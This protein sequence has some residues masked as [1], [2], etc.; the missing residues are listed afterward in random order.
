MTFVSSPHPATILDEKLLK[1]CVI[2]VGR[3]NSGPGGQHRNK[4]ETSVRI[5]HTPTG[6]KGAGNER[7]SQHQN[8]GAALRRL[9][10]AL[11]REIRTKVNPQ[12]YEV[13]DMWKSRRQGRTVSISYKHHDYP[14]L[15][16]EALDI[17]VAKGFDVAGAAGI[18]GISMSQLAKLVRHDKL[19]FARVN[20]NR[21]DSGLPALK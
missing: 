18:M 15:L 13:S 4:V 9:R 20:K 12:K 7:R 14:A 11:A 3:F 5:E 6:I 21:V 2:N 19:A 10:L 8:K 17:I 1:Q 16:A